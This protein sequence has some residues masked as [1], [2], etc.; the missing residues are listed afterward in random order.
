MRTAKDAITLPVI[1]ET[2]RGHRSTLEAMG[3][4][5]IGVF[6]SFVRGDNRPDSDIDILIDHGRGFALFDLVSCAHFAPA[7]LVA[8]ASASQGDKHTSTHS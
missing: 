3:V 5:R 6:G 4:T 2:L 1:V 7:G 8:Q